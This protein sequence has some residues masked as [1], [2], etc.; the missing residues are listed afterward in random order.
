[1]IEV[2]DEIAAMQRRMDDVVREFL[3][4]RARVSHPGSPP[5]LRR[6]FLPATDVFAR[7]DDIVVRLE[8]PGIDPEKDL[9]VT[10]E[11]G[12]LVIGGER[13]RTEEVQDEEYYRMEALFGQFE[14]RLPMPEGIDETKIA[15]EYSDGILEVIVPKAVKALETSKAKT[16]PVKAAKVL[17]TKAA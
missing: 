12:Q 3:G 2:W 14:R 10:L 5:F 11:E 15:A 9:F 4:P 17:K 16:I 6:P 13:K 8:I 1:V 7:D